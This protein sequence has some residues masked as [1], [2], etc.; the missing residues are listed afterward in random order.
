MAAHRDALPLAAPLLLLGL[1]A[2][3]QGAAC[4]LAGAACP[5]DCP[6]GAKCVGSACVC[7][8]GGEFGNANNCGACGARCAA[9]TKCTTVGKC[10]TTCGGGPGSCAVLDI[11]VDNCGACGAKCPTGLPN[12][13][14]MRCAAGACAIVACA[15]GFA[16]CDGALANG[17]E[18]DT[19]TDAANCG[20]CGQ[21]AALTNAAAACM[22]GAPAVA[23]C[24]RGFADC[25]GQ[26]ANGCE[27]DVASDPQNCGGCGAVASALNAASATCDR[28]VP[29]PASC[30]AGFADCDC[31]TGNGCETDLRVDVLN[32]GYCKRTVSYANA[33]P[34]C[35]GGV[36]TLGACNAGF[37]N[38]NGNATDGCEVNTN[39]S[40]AHCGA[41]GAA[42]TLPNTV[43][44]CAGGV[45]AIGACNAGFAN[46]DGLVAN[47]C[48]V[49]LATSAGNCGACGTVCPAATPYCS[50]STCVATE[51]VPFTIRND[52]AP[53]LGWTLRS[54]LLY[55]GGANIASALAA[56]AATGHTRVLVGCAL[57]GAPTMRVAAAGPL[58]VVSA[59]TALNTP[60]QSGGVWWYWTT[61]W[62]FG[63]SESSSIN[64]NQA[65]VSNLGSNLRVSWHEDF[66]GWRCGSLYSLSSSTSYLKIIYSAP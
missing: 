45:R 10:C 24:A 30:S 36:P 13:A 35:V 47:G 3:L 32:C 66:Y 17:C 19:N 9:G 43:P 62:S 8:A 16:D 52:V 31:S 53:P 18:V 25:D 12:V 5:D 37:A 28:G 40:V 63:F 56:A 57:V 7:P 51:V 58:S 23:S 15:D 26:A 65:D 44:A 60:V 49:N 11:D 34:A 54:S 42:V 59:K 14:S 41:C 4:Q 29:R 33:A 38:C 50:A 1:L 20:A 21:K 6:A 61:G 2:A 46:C 55:N 64:Q 27:T 22:G 39:T 48:E